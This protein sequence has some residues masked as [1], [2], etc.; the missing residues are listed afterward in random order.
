MRTI[1]ISLF[2]ALALSAC[3]SDRDRQVAQLRCA[4]VGIS[5][6]SPEYAT[7]TQAYMRMQHEASLESSFHNLTAP[8]PNMYRDS[9]ARNSIYGATYP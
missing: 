5:A 9:S 7:C 2:A 4:E 1:A 8:A 6:S 3:A